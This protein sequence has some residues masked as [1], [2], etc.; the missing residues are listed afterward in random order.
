MFPLVGEA[1]IQCQRVLVAVM[2]NHQ[3][4]THHFLMIATELMEF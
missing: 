4:E 2:R 3:V 1:S